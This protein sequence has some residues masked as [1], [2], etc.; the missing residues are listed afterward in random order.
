VTDETPDPAPGWSD[1]SALGPPAH[2]HL[3]PTLGGT[4]LA[5][6]DGHW[7]WDGER[8]LARATEGRPAA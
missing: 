2:F 7:W 3:D 8:W 1:P 4:P 5:S 6:P